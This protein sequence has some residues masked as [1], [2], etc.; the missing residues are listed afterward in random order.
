MLLPHLLH[1]N[2]LFRKYHVVRSLGPAKLRSLQNWC[3]GHL[4]PPR[5]GANLNFGET[6]DDWRADIYSYTS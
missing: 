4:K 6:L 3:D 1:L 2:F 5:A